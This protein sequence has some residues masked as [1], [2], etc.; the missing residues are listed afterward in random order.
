MKITYYG[1][2]CFS[3]FAGGKNILFDPFITPNELA[4]EIN[5]DGIKADYI[6]VSHAH[7][8]HITD[9]VRIANQTGAMV[10]GI[11]E[12]NIWFNKNGIKNSHPI[13]P[14]GQFSFDFGT[15]KCVIAQHSSSFADGSYGGLACGFVFKTDD[16]N[17]YYSGDTGLT[18]DMKLIPG[19]AELDFAVLPI[20]DGLTMGVNE[21]V[22]A[23]AFVKVNKVV[24]VHYDTFEL[25]KIDHRVAVETFKKAAKTLYL[26]GI[27]STIEVGKD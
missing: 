18:L 2:S 15:V 11:W 24:G 6:F 22:E 3:V 5:I 25:I 9:V 20:G 27:G 17:F 26:M 21:A 8:D 7:Y 1:H 19:W 12:L 14:G 4:K 23:A 13:N 16:G 10:L